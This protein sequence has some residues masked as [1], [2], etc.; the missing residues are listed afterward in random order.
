MKQSTVM[1]LWGEFEVQSDVE[2]RVLMV[3]GSHTQ[4]DV[5]LHVCG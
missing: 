5:Y 1:G 3:Y 2:S 4:G